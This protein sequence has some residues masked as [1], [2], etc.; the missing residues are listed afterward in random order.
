MIH[1][2]T[3]LTLLYHY[4]YPRTINVAAHYRINRGAV[5]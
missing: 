5:L 3:F 4:Y 1:V 2:I